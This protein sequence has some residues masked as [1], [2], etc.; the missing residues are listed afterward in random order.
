MIKISDIKI[1]KLRVGCFKNELP[2]FFELKNCIENNSWHN[3]ESVF[4][5]TLSVLGEF[6][7]LIKIINSKVYCYLNQ[8][9][10]SYSRKDLIFTAILFHD[11]SK[12]DTLVKK[13]DITFCLEH[14]KIGAEKVTKIL[15]RFD[16]SA[17]EKSI[18][19][20]LVRYHGEIHP[21]VSSKNNNHEKHLSCFKSKHCDTFIELILLGISDTSGSQLKDNNTSEYNF[22]INC[23]KNIIQNYQI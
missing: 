17:R 15:N 2:E 11:I 7:K 18:I 12:N 3:N 1:E 13:N 23:Y 8:I 9:I 14:E 5:H 19:I 22:R 10:D 6:E 16:L 20:N 4:D 21:V